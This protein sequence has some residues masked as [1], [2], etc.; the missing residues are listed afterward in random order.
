MIVDPVMF[1]QGHDD[2]GKPSLGQRIAGK[3]GL[4]GMA[5]K[6]SIAI[7]ALVP[8]FSGCMEYVRSI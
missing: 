7:I 2:T 4:G 6:K 3:I 5:S 8:S 1:P